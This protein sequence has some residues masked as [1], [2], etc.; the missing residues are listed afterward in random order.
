MKTTI[1]AIIWVGLLLA[2]SACTATPSAGWQH[3]AAKSQQQAA[4]Q[5]IKQLQARY[6]EVVDQLEN[7]SDSTVDH[8]SIIDSLFL[9]DARWV[10]WVDGEQQ[11]AFNG[12]SEL[13]QFAQWID[14]ASASGAFRKHIS[15][16]SRITVTGEQTLATEQLLMFYAGNASGTQKKIIMGKYSDTLAQNDAGEWRFQSRI[17][18]FTGITD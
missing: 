15:T 3:S 5:A 9:A 16:N 4:V 1:A 12:K 17:L 14:S 11:Q 7:H 13:L 2:I 8:A 6:F 18:R 10:M